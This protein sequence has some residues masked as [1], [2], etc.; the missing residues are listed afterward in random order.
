[1]A[2][3]LII[4]FICG[5]LNGNGGIFSVLYSLSVL[6]WMD[7]FLVENFGI[8]MSGYIGRYLENLFFCR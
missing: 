1:M 6:G 5:E 4:F 3:G 7:L 8:S 2:P